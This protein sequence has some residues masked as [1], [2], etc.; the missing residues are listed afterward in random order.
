MYSTAQSPSE[1]AALKKDFPNFVLTEFWGVRR[2][3]SLACLCE[4]RIGV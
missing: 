2:R 4:S 1:E 3:S